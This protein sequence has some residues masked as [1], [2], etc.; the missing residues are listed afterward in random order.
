M[1]NLTSEAASRYLPPH[2]I[3]EAHRMAGWP[4]P[5]GWGSYQYS[6]AE[7]P[8]PGN[9]EEDVVFVYWDPLS[10]TGLGVEN[11]LGGTV[12]TAVERLVIKAKNRPSSRKVSWTTLNDEGQFVIPTT[13]KEEIQA[14]L[15]SDHQ[16]L[17]NA[18]KR[19]ILSVWWPEFN[20]NIPRVKA[21][22]WGYDGNALLWPG[23]PF[24]LLPCVAH[25][26]HI[27]DLEM[28][29]ETEG[30]G[31]T[32]RTRLASTPYDDLRAGMG[33]GPM[34]RPLQGNIGLKN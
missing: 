18:W 7:A 9:S 28:V 25:P 21:R 1:N 30:W 10:V 4:I 20:K 32:H 15:Y 2:A 24:E 34:G 16:V 23:K 27:R 33:V 22:P 14:M 26:S 13:R 3:T 12:A 5:T 6:E 19:E 11:E 17:T 8:N 29:N 31:M